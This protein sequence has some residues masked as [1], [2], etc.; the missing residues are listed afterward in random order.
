TAGVGAC[1]AGKS[2]GSTARRPAAPHSPGLVNKGMERQLRRAVRAA[3]MAAW[4]AVSPSTR[5][6]PSATGARSLREVVRASTREGI[7][8]ESLLIFVLAAAGLLALFFALQDTSH[9]LARWSQFVDGIRNL[10]S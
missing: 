9:L 5:F 7:D 4:E 1:V 8:R 10:I 6:Q 2:V 3:E